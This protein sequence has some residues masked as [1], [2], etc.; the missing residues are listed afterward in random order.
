MPGYTVIQPNPTAY[1]LDFNDVVKHRLGYRSSVWIEH[2]QILLPGDRFLLI[3]P[4]CS[5]PR[6]ACDTA[7]N[8]GV[9]AQGCP[10]IFRK[11]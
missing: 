10:D 7:I 9:A 8:A 6:S 2:P 4:I 11:T 1:N 3:G 5:D